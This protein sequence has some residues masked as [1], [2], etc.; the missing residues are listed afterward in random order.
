MRFA[1]LIS[2]YLILCWA[3]IISMRPKSLV[4]ELD[5]DDAETAAEKA[6]RQEALDQ[7]QAWP[8]SHKFAW[9]TRWVWM[10]RHEF[11]GERERQMLSRAIDA[12]YR[13]R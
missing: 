13:R 11:D 12:A 2:A 7:R 3:I 4:R 9:E 5:L 10:S 1:L 6:A 8:P